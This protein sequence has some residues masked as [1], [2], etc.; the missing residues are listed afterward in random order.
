[1]VPARK[2][3]AERKELAS[4]LLPALAVYVSPASEQGRDFCV[5][6]CPGDVPPRAP[7]ERVRGQTCPHPTV[8]TCMFK[9]GLVDPQSHRLSSRWLQNGWAQGMAI[10]SRILAW[11]TPWTEE[12]MRSQRV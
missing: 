4:T 10:H 6:P 5:S 3:L 8:T 1:M 7:A 11:R 9:D 12:S 2:G